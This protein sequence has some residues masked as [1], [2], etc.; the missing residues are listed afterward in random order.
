[1]N[2]KRSLNRRIIAYVSVFVALIAVL[3]I[4]NQLSNNVNSNAD[5]PYQKPYNQL[6]PETVKLLK[7]E[8]YQ[9]IILPAQLDQKLSNKESGFVYFFAAT[10]PHCRATTPMLSPLANELKVELPK[11]NLDEFQEG[12]RKYNIQ[13]TPTLVYFKDGKEVERIEGGYAEDGTG[14]HSKQ[15]FTD[16]LNKYKGL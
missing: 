13:Y 2:K 5:N 12:W 16:F 3:I 10:C 8:N 14:G 15:T 9:N 4:I 1:M 7:D 11:Y 6:N